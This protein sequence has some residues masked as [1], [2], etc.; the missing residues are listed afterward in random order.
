MPPEPL[1]RHVA[2]RSHHLA[3]LGQF[4]SLF[5]L[6]Q[7]EVGDPDVPQ[8]VQEQVRRFDIAVQDATSMGVLHGVGHL[9][10]DPRDFAKVPQLAQIAER[11]RFE[12]R[13]VTA[14]RLVRPTPVRDSPGSPRGIRIER[15]DL[16]R[17][18]R[19]QP[20][21]GRR[22]EVPGQQS[23]RGRRR[24]GHGGRGRDSE[25][26]IGADDNVG[27]SALVTEATNVGQNTVQGLP[28]D[29]RHGVIADPVVV[30]VIEDTHDV[31]V[32]QPG[33]QTRLGVEPPHVFRVGPEPR[34]HDLERD[35]A[36]ERFVLGLVDDPHPAAAN[37]PHDHVIAQPL[38]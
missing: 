32:V 10:P 26:R 7:A 13:R 18:L 34:M 9:C 11:R 27:A 38:G 16:F 31:R 2:Q 36:L 22:G 24:P 12:Q 6:G 28:L 37:P 14:D 30:A 15:A 1:G 20:A 25:D 29:E 3:R 17:S 21:R 23:L 33:R 8:R 5:E 19:R 35:S 4:V